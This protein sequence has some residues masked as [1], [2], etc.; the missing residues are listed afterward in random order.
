M[1]RATTIPFLSTDRVSLPRARAAM[2]SNV[3]TTTKA[4]AARKPRTTTPPGAQPQLL[5]FDRI[6]AASKKY[7]LKMQYRPVNPDLYIYAYNGAMAGMSSG[8]IVLGDADYTNQ[9]I[10]AGLW[11]Q[12]LDESYASAENLTQVEAQ[13]AYLQS[14]GIW[15]GRGPVPSPVPEVEGKVKWFGDVIASSGL[16]L[17]SQ[18]IT[19]SASAINVQSAIVTG[20]SM[21]LLGSRQVFATIVMTLAYQL[22]C[23]IAVGFSLSG[24]SDEG[25]SLVLALNIDE[26]ISPYTNTFPFAPPAFATPWYAQVLLPAGEHQFDL[27]ANTIDEDDATLGMAQMSIIATPG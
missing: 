26:A 21:N 1:R 16:Y 7:G 8:R 6:K 4:P 22:Y 15:E 19:P 12:T 2:K 18:G 14:Y 25:N 20:T 3:K 27:L 23:N 5:D 10:C 24:A 11:A 9:V 17:A 13:Q